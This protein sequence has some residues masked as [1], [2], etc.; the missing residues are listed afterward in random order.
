MRKAAPAKK[1]RAAEGETVEGQ[2]L[3]GAVTVEI[4]IPARWAWH[5]HSAASRRAHGAAYA[6]YVGSWRRRFRIVSGEDEVKRFRHEA[7][8]TIRSF[9]RRCGP[10]AAS[11]SGA[12]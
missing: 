7:T 12:G 1:V 4:G 9:C 10:A 6:T 8:G 11:A 3:C 5:D 2:C